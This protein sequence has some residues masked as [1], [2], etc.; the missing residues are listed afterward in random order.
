ML[1]YIAKCSLDI[2]S[3]SPSSLC[4]FDRYDVIHDV[5][6]DRG[7]TWRTRGRAGGPRSRPPR[8][9]CGT[10]AW[11]SAPCAPGSETQR[12]RAPRSH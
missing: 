6:L 4:I 5:I 7:R 3:K 1:Q 2:A 12:V 9:P 10:P 8:A 11:R